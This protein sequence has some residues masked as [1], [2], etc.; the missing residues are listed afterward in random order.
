MKTITLNIFDFDELSESA[1]ERAREWYRD[2]ALDYEWWDS[3]YEDAKSIGLKLTGFDLDRN[4]HATG[5]FTESAYVV[6]NAIKATHGASCE[7]CKTASQYLADYSKLPHESDETYDE[8]RED[9]D[10]EFLKSLLEDYSIILQK[11]YEYILSDESV[12]ETIR[13]NGYTF[14]ENG[15]REG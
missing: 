6:A 12:D 8:K 14:N 5:K 10:G 9:L 1:K 4:R 11:E 15:K 2:G 13:A 3:I 7:T